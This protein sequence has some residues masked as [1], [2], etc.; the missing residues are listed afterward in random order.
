[1]SRAALRHFRV[2][3]IETAEERPERYPRRRKA[4]IANRRAELG[5]ESA[6]P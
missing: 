6:N 1:M 3:R 2:D 5:I 4:L